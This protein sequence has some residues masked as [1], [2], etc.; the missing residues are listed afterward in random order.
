M[1]IEDERIL[2]AIT[3][4]LYPTIAKEFDTTP[5]RVERAI[6]HAIEIGWNRGNIEFM[7]RIFGY[8]VSVVNGKPTNSEFIATI[9]DCLK[10]KTEI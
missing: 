3:K 2:K 8:T 9:V 5:N 4:V 6:R 1:V 7:E 10:M